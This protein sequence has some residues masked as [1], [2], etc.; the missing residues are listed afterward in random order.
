MLMDGQI[1]SA[2][3]RK[4]AAEAEQSLA[5]QKPTQRRHHPGV[6]KLA[7]D[8]IL[9]ALGDFIGGIFKW[10]E[11]A[12]LHQAI[13]LFFDEEDI[14]EVHHWRGVGGKADAGGELH[15]ERNAASVAPFQQW[16]IA[17]EYFFQV[18]ISLQVVTFGKE[19]FFGRQVGYG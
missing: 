4:A 8:H 14:A 10:G 1:S 7:K 5:A 3:Y 6:A 2:H 19:G 13:E 12:A 15:I 9:D 17:Q 11:Q 18:E 16:V